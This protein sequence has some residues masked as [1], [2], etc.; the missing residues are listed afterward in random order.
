VDLSTVEAEY[1]AVC[2][3]VCEALWF[4]KFLIGLFGQMLD[5]TVIHSDN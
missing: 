5:P 4:W 2:V 3:A 1:I